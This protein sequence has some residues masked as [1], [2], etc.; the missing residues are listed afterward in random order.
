[1]LLCF[2]PNESQTT[3]SQD[4]LLAG[5]FKANQLTVLKLLS[6]QRSFMTRYSQVHGD[7]LPLPYNMNGNK[8]GYV[9]VFNDPYVK[10]LKKMVNTTESP[11][12]FYFFRILKVKEWI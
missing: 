11:F 4:T 3:I 1:M 5:S 2:L 10:A 12:S 9:K 6:G 8:I 7:N